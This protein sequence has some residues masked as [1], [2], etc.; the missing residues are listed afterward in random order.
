[1]EMPYEITNSFDTYI[2]SYGLRPTEYTTYW[3][4]WRYMNGKYIQTTKSSQFSI[5]GRMVYSY[6]EFY[7][8]DQ[9]G[10]EIAILGSNG[11]SLIEDK[12][13]KIEANPELYNATS[14]RNLLVVD[15]EIMSYDSISKLQI[16]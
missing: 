11:K 12:I 3:D 8:K 1:M 7:A 9:T 16:S 14:K 15:N 13:N 2:Y 4:V 10:F 6:A 5:V